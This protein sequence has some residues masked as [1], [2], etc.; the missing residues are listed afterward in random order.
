[1]DPASV[2]EPMM[3][4]RQE[5][6]APVTTSLVPRSSLPLEVPRTKHIKV[7]GRTRAVMLVEE[8]IGRSD[9]LIILDKALQAEFEADPAKF[10]RVYVMPF[11]PKESRV[12]VTKFPVEIR[13]VNVQV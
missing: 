11:I 12:E 5:L 7:S 6:L 8:V 2:G 13:L 10:F 4:E 1:M 9:N 3:S